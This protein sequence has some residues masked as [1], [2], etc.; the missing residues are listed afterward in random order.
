MDAFYIALVLSGVLIIEPIVMLLCL[1]NVYTN[2]SASLTGS[3]D[4]STSF[5]QESLSCGEVSS[6][7]AQLNKRGVGSPNDFE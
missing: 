4:Q 1:S 5:D 2:D 7:L 6:N 3:C